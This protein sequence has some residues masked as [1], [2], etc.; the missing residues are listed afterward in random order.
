MGWE[1]R[2]EEAA[3]G[4]TFDSAGVSMLVSQDEVLY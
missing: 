3:A 4:L 1:V 2:T